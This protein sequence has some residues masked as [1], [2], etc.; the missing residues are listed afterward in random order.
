MEL[1]DRQMDV[2]CLAAQGYSAPE[3]GR[4]LF[5]SHKTVKVHMGYVRG[6]LGARNT[7]HAVGIAMGLGII[8]PDTVLA[9]A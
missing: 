8:H 5:I 3:I 4:K 6:K 9:A 2:L 1:T 7:A